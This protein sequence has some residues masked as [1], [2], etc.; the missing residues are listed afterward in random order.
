[1]AELK[2]RDYEV[3]LGELGAFARAG[4]PTSEGLRRLASSKS[5]G[6]LAK[7]AKSAAEAVEQGASLSEAV[8]RAEPP[9]PEEIV[10]VVRCAENSPEGFKL[11]RHAALHLRSVRRF[12]TIL[13]GAAIYPLAVCILALLAA[14]VTTQ[15]LGGALLDVYDR[16][17]ASNAD[18][19]QQFLQFS[20]SPITLAL[21]AAMA[22]GLTLVLAIS[23]ARER[24]VDLLSKLPLASRVIRAAELSAAMRLLSRLLRDGAPP[25]ASY[26]AASVFLSGKSADAFR[27]MAKAAE[28]GQPAS[29]HLPATMPATAGYMFERGEESGA[30]ADSCEAIAEYCDDLGARL[31][32]AVGRALGPLL[33]F[34]PLALLF[35]LLSFLY[36]PLFTIP[37]AFGAL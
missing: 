7:L 31:G 16:L 17:P 2:P 34:I 18:F 27:A 3:F 10:A 22:L 20:T 25:D 11:L 5:Q 6:A 15:T 37:D 26:R 4:M 14:M 29:P 21:L 30:L 35:V 12:R 36:V 28:S 23:G 32:P 19:P 33:I 24:V 9:P 8:A 13:L 1:M